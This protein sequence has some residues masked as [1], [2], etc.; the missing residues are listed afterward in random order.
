[1]NR[2]LPRVTFSPRYNDSSEI[3]AHVYGPSFEA[4]H[5]QEAVSALTRLV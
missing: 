3:L 5:D 4:Y 2:T 1:M